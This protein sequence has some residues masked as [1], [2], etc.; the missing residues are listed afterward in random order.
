[1]PNSC[2]T[3]TTSNTKG[4]TRDA[5]QQIAT[6]P[7]LHSERICPHPTTLR[8]ITDISV[9]TKDSAAPRRTLEESTVIT[10]EKATPDPPPHPISR[11]NTHQTRKRPAVANNPLDNFVL[12]LKEPVHAHELAQSY[13]LDIWK[14]EA[15]AQ[16]EATDA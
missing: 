3:A 11:G 10:M 13:G 1:M 4:Q 7:L 6:N 12:R 2:K 9:D 16:E 8:R 14:L 15:S 5:Q